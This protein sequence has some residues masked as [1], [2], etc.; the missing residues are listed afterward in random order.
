MPNRAQNRGTVVRVV[1]PEASGEARGAGMPQGIMA[2]PADVATRRTPSRVRHCPVAPE[3]D[4]VQCSHPPDSMRIPLLTLGLVA[5][6]APLAAQAGGDRD[7]PVPEGGIKVPGWS[8]R[9]DPNEEKQGV[10]I[11]ATRLVPEGDGMHVTSGPAAIYWNP[12]NRGTGS[13]TVKATFTLGRGARGAEYY[14]VFAGGS[15]LDAAGQ[16]YLYC[17]IAANGTFTVKHR[18][19]GE[20]HELAGRTAHAAIRKASA[21][22]EATNEVAWRVTPARTSC[23]VNGTEVWGYPSRDLVGPGKLESNEGVVGLRVNHNLDL[24][25]TGFALTRP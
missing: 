19:G 4:T 5:L 21:Q 20:V 14:G 25:I 10:K 18:F 24:R 22:G 13:Y 7:R 9:V 23:L 3:A 6:A 1:K 12:A 8:G 11:T 15:R 2:G 17:V 16:N